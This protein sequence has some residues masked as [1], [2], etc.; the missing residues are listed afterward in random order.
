MRSPEAF[1]P[2]DRLFRIDCRDISPSRHTWGTTEEKMEVKNGNKQKTSI[3]GQWFYLN[4]VNQWQTD[5]KQEMADLVEVHLSYEIIRT[6]L[7]VTA[8]CF[9]MH[10]AAIA[11]VPIK[12]RL[13]HLVLPAP[14]R[15]PQV[16]SSVWG[17]QAAGD[18]RGDEL[19]RRTTTAGRLVNSESGEIIGSA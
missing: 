17:E 10:G 4:V 12:N 15:G 8:V 19:E 6:D 11:L 1:F 9:Q 5:S 7:P 18:R 3:Q 2:R 14:Q 16:V 13:F